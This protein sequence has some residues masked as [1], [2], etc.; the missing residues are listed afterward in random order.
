MVINAAV[1]AEKNTR[2]IKAA[3]QPTSGS[4]HPKRF[5]G[6]LPGNPS[7]NFFGLGSIFQY[8]ERNYMVAK[9]MEEY[10][11][12]SE[13]GAYED[14]G[15]RR[16]FDSCPQEEDFMTEMILTGGIKNTHHLPNRPD[17]GIPTARL[18]KCT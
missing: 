6:I 12:S 2:T 16:K 5:M 7:T 17:R 11:L 4:L 18:P 14:Q 10:K 15:G 8:K 1:E 13:E 3:V 9:A